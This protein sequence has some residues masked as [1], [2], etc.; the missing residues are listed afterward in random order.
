MV[1]G[2]GAVDAILIADDT[3]AIKKGSKSVGVAPQHCGLTNQIENCQ[4][5][6]MLT[7][8]T[9]AGHAFIDRALYLPEAWTSAEARGQPPAYQPSRASRR[10]LNWSNGCCRGSAPRLVRCGLRL[11]P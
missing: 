2:L 8:A 11:R 1:A 5:M 9:Q 7:Y 3:Q 6:P 4:V 10:N